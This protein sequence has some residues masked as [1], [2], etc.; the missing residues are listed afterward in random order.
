MSC[1]LGI[2]VWLISKRKLAAEQFGVRLKERLI[3]IDTF[4]CSMYPMSQSLLA[5]IAI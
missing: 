4:A 3:D 2:A 5:A 1:Y